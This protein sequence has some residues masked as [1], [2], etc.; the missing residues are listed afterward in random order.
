M[1]KECRKRSIKVLTLN[2]K[3]T[4]DVAPTTYCY[5]SDFGDSDG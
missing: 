5:S 1:N 2:D 3:L 4:V